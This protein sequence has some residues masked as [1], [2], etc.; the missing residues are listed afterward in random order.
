M[1]WRLLKVLEYE[2]FVKDVNIIDDDGITTLIDD[3][4]TMTLIAI[5]T[6]GG[7]YVNQITFNY[8]GE[9]HPRE[10]FEKYNFED[11]KLVTVSSGHER[12]FMQSPWSDN[13]KR[14]IDEVIMEHF[15]ELMSLRP[16]LK[17]IISSAIQ[18]IRLI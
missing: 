2:N 13:H 5:S 17:P 7:S 15:D 14:S 3:D 10:Y 8:Q 11:N 4:S 1:S 9:N 6:E 16:D 12:G 18:Q